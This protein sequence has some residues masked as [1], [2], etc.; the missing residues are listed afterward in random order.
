MVYNTFHNCDVVCFCSFFHIF[1]QKR[2][3]LQYRS[4][5][6]VEA[7]ARQAQRMRCDQGQGGGEPSDRIRLEVELASDQP[8]HLLTERVTRPGSA[9]LLTR[10][11]IIRFQS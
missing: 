5:K 4:P 8:H 11:T 9:Q 7:A 3:Q 2:N 10:P 6:V 1:F